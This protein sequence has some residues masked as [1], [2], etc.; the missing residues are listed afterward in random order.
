MHCRHDAMTLTLADYPTALGLSEQNW[1]QSPVQIMVLY[2]VDSLT[3]LFVNNSAKIKYL[4]TFFKMGPTTQEATTA[5]K[6]VT[7]C[8]HRRRTT[9]STTLKSCILIHQMGVF[10]PTALAK[11]LDLHGFRKEGNIDC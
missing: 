11:V 8:F 4:I 2:S 6:C 1:H 3:E 5:V 10:G 7:A 9:K